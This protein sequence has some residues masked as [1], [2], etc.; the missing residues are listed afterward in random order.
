MNTTDYQPRTYGGWRQSR[1]L[2]AFGMTGPETAGVALNLFLLVGTLGWARDLLALI[3]GSTIVTIGL[4]ARIDGVAVWTYG[5]REVAWHTRRARGRGEFISPL[6]RHQPGHTDTLP[7]PMAATEMFEVA[8]PGYPSY[9]AVFNR[10]TSEVTVSFFGHSQTIGLTDHEEMDVWVANWGAF[11]AS[12]PDIPQ[13]SYVAVTV[14]TSTDPS[15][16]VA[17]NLEAMRDHDA[18]ELSTKIMNDVAAR[19]GAGTQRTRTMVSVTFDPRWV[20][21]GWARQPETFIPELHGHVMSISS[22]LRQCGLT[23]LRPATPAELGAEVR[24]AFTPAVAGDAYEA[25]RTPEGQASL[26]WDLVGPATAKEERTHYCHD[27]ARSVAWAL[28]LPPREIVTAAILSKILEPG[29]FTKR[30]T[31]WWHPLPAAK[32]QRILESERFVADVRRRLAQQ[33]QSH[34]TAREVHDRSITDAAARHEAEG[35][36]YGTFTLVAAV[37]V[38]TGDELSDAGQ[39]QLLK[40]AEL[41]VTNGA[42]GSRLTLRRL[43]ASHGLGLMATLPVGINLAD[44]LRPR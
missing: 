14:A 42:A 30:V 18:P 27:N 9:G 25:V 44:S 32:A 43:D 37:T 39:R 1:G 40:Q 34:E 29:T 3:V 5:W 8:V 15:P 19:F 21:G 2:G 22:A 11:L 28:V 36:G 31:L 4:V 38:P 17:R 26:R 7:G 6:I 20:D 12:C 41:D 35:A 24:A 23:S 13:I 33:N 16:S 10:R